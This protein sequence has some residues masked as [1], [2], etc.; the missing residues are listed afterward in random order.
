M[1]RRGAGQGAAGRTAAPLNLGRPCGRHSRRHP[2]ATG[3][4]FLVGWPRGG[5]GC[6]P[7]ES[8]DGQAQR[9]QRRH[10]QHLRRQGARGAGGRGCTDT[11]RLTLAKPHRHA[12][13]PPAP[14]AAQSPRRAPRSQ[15]PEKCRQPARRLRCDGER[16]RWHVSTWH[17]LHL[18]GGRPA[19]GT[20]G[21]AEDGAVA[22]QPQT[23]LFVR[24][25]PPTK[26]QLRHR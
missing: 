23:D 25:A 9:A 19:P 24:G 12:A 14:G 11:W 2:K 16:R 3:C 15:H 7:K 21:A 4:W 6:P 1:G 10:R 20:S 8:L 26:L 5:R 22:V 17:S 13:S 18:L